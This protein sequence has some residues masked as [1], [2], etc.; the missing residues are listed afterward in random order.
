MFQNGLNE[1]RARGSITRICLAYLSHL[2]LAEQRPV[3]KIRIEFPLAQYS[4]QYW[5]EHA[6]PAETEKDVQ[7]RILNFFL[8]QR[9]TYAAWGELFDLDLPW[10]EEP[11]Q[12][13]EMATL[14]YY[15]Y[16]AGLH[17]TVEV[18]LEKGADFNAQG[19]RLDNALEAASYQGHKETVQ[20]L[21]E[22]RADV[23]VQGCF[24]GNALR[25]ASYQGHKETV[26]L[27]LEKG[28]ILARL[29]DR[30][31]VLIF[32]TFRE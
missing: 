29:S 19:G 7:E 3:R 21:L 28:A 26:R 13:R 2:D 5:M 12:W 30:I 4:A 22:K 31:L 10:A 9:Q 6:R 18:L 8:Q 32:L 17:N 14:L 23:N 24:Y 16:L 1:V 20:L 25:T 11:R 15:T 27:L